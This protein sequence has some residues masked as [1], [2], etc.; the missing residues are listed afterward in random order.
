MIS[1]SVVLVLTWTWLGGRMK[2]ASIIALIRDFWLLVWPCDVG[3]RVR[4]GIGFN[5]DA[6]R[7]GDR[8]Q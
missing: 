3:G 1:V 2:G 5:L 8:F 4:G 6:R 7:H